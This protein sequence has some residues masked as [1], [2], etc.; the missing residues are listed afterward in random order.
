M[1][2]SLARFLSVILHPLLMPTILFGLLLFQVPA[3]L[4]MDAF[5]KSLR[6]SLL[7]LIF[8]GTFMVPSLLIYYLYRSGYVKSLQLTNLADR[9]LPYFL[10]GI[11]YLFVAYLFTFQMQLISTLAPEVG[12][13]IGSM[14]VSILFV[15]IISLSWQ[16]SAHT[17]GIGGVVGLITS[18]MIKFSITELFFPLLLLV[19]L[20]GLVA[21][22]RLQLNAHTPAQVS[23]GL[24]LGLSV[25][26]L[27]IYWFV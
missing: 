13:M 16:I 14:A 4:G 24:A 27:T 17:V 25:S 10:T 21:S 3:V 26:L 12:I 20:T 11:V 6:L 9:R 18:I 22:A 2:K 23:A 1:T 8:V 15:G 7:I 19:L 5:S